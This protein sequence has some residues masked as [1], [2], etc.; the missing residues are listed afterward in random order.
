MPPGNINM[1]SAPAHNNYAPQP[2]YVS[3]QQQYVQ[4]QQYLSQQSSSG[5]AG[6]YVQSYQGQQQM[7]MS[8]ATMSSGFNSGFSSG[9]TAGFGAYDESTPDYTQQA[10][11]F[12]AGPGGGYYRPSC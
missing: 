5:P 11:M 8:G 6:G 12:G 2:Q 10:G 4:Q 1:Y 7:P 3:A 9:N